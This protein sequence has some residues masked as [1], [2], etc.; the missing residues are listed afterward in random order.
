MDYHI[1]C[2]SSFILDANKWIDW[3]FQLKHKT[4]INQVFLHPNK[5][6]DMSLWDVR[7][8]SGFKIVGDCLS[9]QCQEKRERKNIEQAMTIACKCSRHFSI[10]YKLCNATSQRKGWVLALWVNI[11]HNDDG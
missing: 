8:Q 1:R 10:K 6:A 9:F 4:K 5:W 2:L 11:I 3:L 7:T